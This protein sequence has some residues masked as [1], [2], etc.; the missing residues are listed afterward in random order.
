MRGQSHAG[1][2][3]SRWEIQRERCR[4]DAGVSSNPERLE[5]VSGVLSRVLKNLG[6]KDQ[7]WLMELAAAWPE[8]V[9]P[10]VASHARPGRVSRGELHV[11]VDSSVWLFELQRFGQKQFLEKV[12]ALFGTDRIRSVRFVMDPERPS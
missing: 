1:K 2:R 5:P 9:G 4:L 11:F 6:L 3:G 10:V 8:M 12:W 7:V